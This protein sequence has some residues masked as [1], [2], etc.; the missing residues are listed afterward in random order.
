M[1]ADLSSDNK[2]LVTCGASSL[3]QLWDISDPQQPVVAHEID[4]GT[5]PASV[6]FNA[7]SSKI[8]ASVG[9]KVR[10]WDTGSGQEIAAPA[11]QA[12]G[13]IAAIAISPDQIS[14]LDVV[15]AME[16]PIATTPT[17]STA[18]SAAQ[19]IEQC[20]SELAEEQ[21]QR[22]AGI[23]FES[24]AREAASSSADMYYI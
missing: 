13:P 19:V 20:W 9:G 16:G 18:T 14:L 3:F 8:V 21:Q 12:I 10:F 22:L 11:N 2:K 4:A 7:D 15:V 17:R 5:R 23:T 24:L 6:A 1:F